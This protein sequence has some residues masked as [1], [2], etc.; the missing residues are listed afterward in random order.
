MATCAEV[1]AD[2]ASG[3]VKVVRAVTAFDCGAVVNPNHLKN[4]IEGAMM[5]GLGGALF[6]AIEFEKGMITNPHL[7]DY[8]VP[9]FTDVAQIRNRSH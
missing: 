1:L 4:Q 3:T 8:R 7:A 6:E 2:T 9:H 5:M